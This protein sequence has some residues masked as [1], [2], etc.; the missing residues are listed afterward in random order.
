MSQARSPEGTPESPTAKLEAIAQKL[1]VALSPVRVVSLSFHDED[2][3][4][5]WLTESV[6]GPDE[7]EAVRSSM[8]IFAGQGAPARHEHDLGDGR[9][10]I[11]WRANH[12]GSSV[13]GVLM[14][15]VDQRS[16]AD[17]KL[18]RA[19]SCVAEAVT[20][21]AEW[22]AA[23]LSATQLRLRALPD[24]S[25]PEPEVN[26]ELELAI[27]DYTPPAEAQAAPVAAV[28]A[29]PVVAVPA[30]TPA[31][32]QPAKVSSIDPSLE[33]H[34]Q[35]LRAQ[36]IVLFAQQL[37]PLTE[38]SRIPRYEILL[39]TGSEH[40][41]SQAPVAMLEAAARKGLGSVLDRRVITDLVV[42]LSRSAEAWHANPISV[43]VNLSST[44][45]VDAHFLKFL[46]ACLTKSGLPRGMIGFE[47]D[48]PVC[49][50]QRQRAAEFAEVLASL[51]CKLVLDNFSLQDGHVELLDLKGLRML[52]LH[53][54]LTNTM[55]IDTR[56]QAVVAGIAQMACVLGMYTCAKSIESKQLQPLLAKLK[57]DFVQGFAY[58]LPR[59]LDELGLGDQALSA[60]R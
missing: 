22:L 40:G 13:L 33:R 9:V 49:A 57:V 47:L 59:P 27:I 43:T 28:A 7:H 15:I 31:G 36:P 37:E 21:F 34:F 29:A 14:L 32:A 53:P 20:G 55:A 2:A 48:A 46:E 51:G 19:D 54:Q 58:S 30:A 45:L 16:M 35:A 38:E 10:A 12:R 26:G 17:P 25:I 50:L 42:W 18:R 24:L 56:R 8:E 5:L 6:L 4:V 3:D 39:R 1:L 23:D 44:S 60:A 52:K 11:T 41:R